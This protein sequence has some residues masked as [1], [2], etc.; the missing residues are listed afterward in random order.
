MSVRVTTSSNRNLSVSQGAGTSASIVV[1]KV[2]SLT[3]QGLS[4]VD[5]TNL[6]DGYT[7]VYDSDTQKWV[8]QAVSVSVGVSLDGGTF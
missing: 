8:A 7:L 3:V 1:Q 5:S 2:G 4:N 6:Q